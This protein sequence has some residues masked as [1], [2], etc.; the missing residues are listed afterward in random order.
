MRVILNLNFQPLGGP[1]SC[2]LG[3]VVLLPVDFGNLRLRRE[4]AYL[5]GAVLVN[6]NVGKSFLALFFHL[7]TRLGGLL[8]LWAVDASILI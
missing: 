7:R 6:P 1:S 8:C 5:I 4:T 2:F 3:C